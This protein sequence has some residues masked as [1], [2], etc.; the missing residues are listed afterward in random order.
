MCAH[1]WLPI[2]KHPVVAMI[3][4]HGVIFH[5]RYCK[6]STCRFKLPTSDAFSQWFW[7]ETWDF[8]NPSL[9]SPLFTLRLLTHLSVCCN[10]IHSRC[11]LPEICE[12][13]QHNSVT[14]MFR[15]CLQLGV[16]LAASCSY[17]S[18]YANCNDFPK[19]LA[20]FRISLQCNFD[21][22]VYSAGITR[23]DIGVLLQYRIVTI[24]FRDSLLE[25]IQEESRLRSIFSE[26]CNHAEL[27]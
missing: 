11:K 6:F 17:E 27:S 18:A 7:L 4:P 9:L 22:L 26:T 19:N 10:Q 13:F 2:L 21:F 12:L 14:I 5:T 8:F 15:D 16:W 24:K 23:V 20:N 3:N 1:N 25:T